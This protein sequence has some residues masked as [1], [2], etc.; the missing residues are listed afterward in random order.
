MLLYIVTDVF[1]MW[2]TS[3]AYTLSL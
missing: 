3:V 1:R 2:W